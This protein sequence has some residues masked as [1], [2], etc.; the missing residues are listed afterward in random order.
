[1]LN[2]FTFLLLGI[3]IFFVGCQEDY[4]TYATPLNKN[5]HPFSCL[6]YTVLD[7][8]DKKKIETA[9]NIVENKNCD[10][11]VE[12]IR[13][14]VGKCNNSLVKSLGGD[15]NGYVR[16][17]VKKG[18]KCYYKIQSDYKN[19]E[20]AAFSRVLEKIKKSF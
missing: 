17:E 2:K 4:P 3:S 19:D 1:M 11:R 10:Y 14:R 20:D 7:K 18:F 15:F 9:F 5:D 12:L 13:Y 8:S 6:H 16:V